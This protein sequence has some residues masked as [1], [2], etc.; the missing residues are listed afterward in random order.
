MFNILI[1]RK[2]QSCILNTDNPFNSFR[3][4]P[5]VLPYITRGS[6]RQSELEEY[7]LPYMPSA[8]PT[9]PSKQNLESYDIINLSV[10]LSQ[11][12]I[13]SDELGHTSSRLN[14]S[15]DISSRLVVTG[16]EVL[17]KLCLL[18]TS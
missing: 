9:L 1:I 8:D 16:G 12:L 6:I 10:S 3:A 11:P 15:H 14:D 2:F 4:L 5:V 17:K 13:L 7:I 18:H